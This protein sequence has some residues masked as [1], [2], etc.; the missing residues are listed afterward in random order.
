MTA[1]EIHKEHIKEHIQEIE[2]AIA[3]GIERRAC[4]N[5]ASCFCTLNRTFGIVSA[6]N[7]QDKLRNND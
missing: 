2:D 3:I 5:R 1:K 7:G 6:Y 4:D